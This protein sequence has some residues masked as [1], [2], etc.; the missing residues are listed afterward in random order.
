MAEVSALARLKS[1]GE[2]FN[3][4]T[5]RNYNRLEG[6]P[7]TAEYL[8]NLA[9]ECH[10][11]LWFLCRQWQFGEFEGED[12]ATAF[13]AN[14]L[15]VHT[16]PGE[17]A[18]GPD[19]TVVA[20]DQGRPLEAQAETEPLVPTLQLRAQMG[21]HL[22]RILARHRVKT[23]AEA[24]ADEFP[25]DRSVDD[26][27]EEG[28]YLATA[29]SSRVPDGLTV[30]E[31]IRAGTLGDFVR[32]HPGIDPAHQEALTRCEAEFVRWFA[33]LYAQ[34]VEGARAWN[35]SHLEYDLSL[36]ARH[37]GSGARVLLADQY[38][39]GR[40]DWKDFDQESMRRRRDVAGLAKPEEVVQTFIPAPLR[41]SGMPHPRLWQMEDAEVD[42][43]T[44]DG[45]PTSVLNVLLAQ[46][47]L[48]YSNDWFV[49]PYE[50]AVNTLCELR[51][52]VV[53]DVFGQHTFVPPALGDPES[54]WEQFAMFHHTERDNETRDRSFFYLCPAVGRQLESEDVERV[55]FIRD[56][57]SNM[58]WGIEQ[59]V[60][61]ATGTG[62]LLARDVPSLA[63]FEPVGEDARIRY[64]LGN[65]VPDNW[66]PFVPVHKP[67]A[68]GEDL[69]EIR[70]QRARMP[71]GRGPR[72]RLL[73]EVQPVFFVE[74]EEVG[75]TGVVVNLR[76]QRTR[77]LNGRTVLWLG[78]RKQMGRGEGAANLRFDS[79]LTIE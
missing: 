20:L 57:M 56:E 48:T 12:A 55:N 14:V 27:D 77:W 76:Y 25:L 74:E 40:L 62:R 47:G 43:G 28:R 71:Q 31:R 53:E 35:P 66:I 3:R 23:Y 65:P 78:R 19:G 38:S 21:R 34:P 50:L 16:R 8:R 24:F 72:S 70:L 6:S 29:L 37:E 46:Q 45:S 59:V 52:M 9:M 49:L 10:D 51:G 13:T 39:G 54:D 63:D 18:L 4:P 11:P 58:V 79:I 68:A 73:G 69:Q 17:L 32:G 42:F 22:V 67:V 15:G 41:F 33:D 30:M 26:D 7:R 1:R 60:P 44:V 75:K 61:S 36:A 5:I 64:V 2:R